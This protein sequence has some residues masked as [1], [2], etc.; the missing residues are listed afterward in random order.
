M[1]AHP[2][3]RLTPDV[4]LDAVAAGGFSPDGRLLGLN[5]YENRVYQVWLDDGQTVKVI[6]THSDLVKALKGSGKG[7]K[8][9]ERLLAERRA[10]YKHEKV[11]S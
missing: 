5:S 4:V 10:E 9:T 6:F 2:Y 3:S 11:R 8:L 7:H 1:D